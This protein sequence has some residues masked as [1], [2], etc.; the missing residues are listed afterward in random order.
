V[1]TVV[2]VETLP[3]GEFLSEIDI[4][5]VGEQLVE[6]PLVG[7]VRSFQLAVELGCSRFDVNVPDS[8]VAYVPVEFRLELVPRSVRIV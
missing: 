1:G 5:P 3:L 8:R 4:A 7:P 2:I 6:R